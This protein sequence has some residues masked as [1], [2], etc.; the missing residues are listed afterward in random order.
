M[1][2]KSEQMRIGMINKEDGKMRRISRIMAIVITVVMMIGMI[3]TF[4]V[5]AAS[6]NKVTWKIKKTKFGYVTK[7]YDNGKLNCTVRTKKKLPIRA[8]REDELADIDIT[9]R[10]NKYI[11]VEFIEGKCINNDGDG[12]TDTGYYISYKRL[13][14]HK[15]GTRY[16]TFCIYDN[17]EYIDDIIG[18]IDHRR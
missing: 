14:N 3:G 15:R 12:I 18:R 16:Q 17:S 2:W 1:L 10:Y 6:K 7:F 9:G 11:V 13:K 8:F 5:D 4:T